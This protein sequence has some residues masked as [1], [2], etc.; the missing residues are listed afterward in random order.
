M[1]RK[2]PLILIFLCTTVPVFGQLWTGVLSPNRAVDWS[3]AG[4]PGGIPSSGAN[5]T[6]CGSTI[7]AG[8]TAA[9]INAAIAACSANQYV[10]LG[11]GTFNLTTGIVFNHKS[12][13]V[14]RG[15]GADQTI[16]VFT[17]YNSCQ[18][19]IAD[20]CFESSDTNYWGAPSNQASWSSG[21]SAGTTSLVLSSKTNLAVG[22]PITLDQLD[23]TSLLLNSGWTLNSG[24]I[25]QVA[26]TT[27]TPVEV[28]FNGVA[29]TQ[30]ASVAGITAAKQWYWSGGVLYVY[31]TSNPATA[32]TSPGLVATTDGGDIFVCYAP[33][34]VCSTNGDSGGAP[35]PGRSQQ[36]MVN[37]TSISGSGPYT[38]G[39][40]PGIYMPNWTA[41]KSPQAWW[42]T[43]PI[44]MSGVENLSIDHTSSGAT[45]GVGIFNC[46]GCWVKG[47]RSIDPGRSHVQILQS[48]HVTVQDSYFYM[49][50]NAT[51]MSYGVETIPSSDTLV[52]NNIFQH[53]S[54]PEVNT[55][56][57]S[58][59]VWAYNFDINEIYLSSTYTWQQQSVYPHSV[60]DDH[61]LM[62]GNQGAGVYSDNFHGSHQFQTI[63]RNAYN[64]FQQNNGTVTTGNTIP[65]VL[66]AFSRFYNVI[67]NVLGSTTLPNSGYESNVSGGSATKPVYSIGFGD[68]VPNDPNTPRTLMRWG[69]Y[70]VITQST[71]TPASSGIR[72]V[73]SEVP[74]GIQN[75]SNPVP[76]TTALPASFYLSAQPSWWPA[77][78]PW[79]AI[80]PDVT[81]GNLAGYAGH[82]YTIPAA[83]CYANVMGGAGNGTGSV[84]SFNATTCYGNVGPNP[85]VGL[86]GTVTP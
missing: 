29:G 80:G 22:T 82:A 59:C 21:Y 31:S 11:A 19:L 3:Q 76:A 6:Q 34:Y 40:T 39:V 57:C 20:V 49:T 70:T 1:K 86:G 13:V 12:N 37:V 16:L 84:L 68:E 42:P 28:Q 18:G 64:G 9:T 83:D 33:Q 2:L 66:N 48:N 43:S 72:F 51:D 30:V 56:A 79:P 58:G 7:A 15:M 60:G 8:A 5:W 45:V 53:I 26:E 69:N 35:R 63:F 55:G 44:S 52:Q 77:T 62:E 73:A 14:L 46:T 17:G 47:I 4:V 10:L 54:G 36:Q 67:G 65:M 27:I 78:K 50:A 25:W 32:F 23:D 85:P 81:G 24:N 74:S 75:Y 38:I 61:I 71:D 41:T